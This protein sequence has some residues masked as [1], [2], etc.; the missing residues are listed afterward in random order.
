MPADEEIGTWL[1]FAPLLAGAAFL[2]LVC[3]R[4]LWVWRV[5]VSNGAAESATVDAVRRSRGGWRKVRYHF[6][7]PL[8]GERVFRG[9]GSWPAGWLG[10]LEPGRVIGVRYHLGHPRLSRI[11]HAGFRDWG[12]W[13]PWWPLR[14]RTQ[15]GQ[16]YDDASV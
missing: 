14:S 9:R 12:I 8:T 16:G 7:T 1:D 11:D 13:W 3:L 15:P 5:L 2:V 10:D 4:E 6:T